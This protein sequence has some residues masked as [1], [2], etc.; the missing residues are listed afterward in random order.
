METGK[1]VCFV[2]AVFSCKIGPIKLVLSD[3]KIEI[4]KA[5]FW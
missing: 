4:Y 5:T 3:Q 2:D 1:R